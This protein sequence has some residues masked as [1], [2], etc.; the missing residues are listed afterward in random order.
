MDTAWFA[1]DRDGRV[2]R[3]DSGEAGA[4]PNEAATGG[5]AEDPSFDVLLLDVACAIDALESAPRRERTFDL[6]RRAILVI[7]PVATGDYRTPAA[8]SSCES[9]TEMTVVRESSPRVLVTKKQLSPSELATLADH[10]DVRVLVTDEELHEWLDGDAPGL[11]QFAHDGEHYN[12]PGAY[13]RAAPPPQPLRLDAIPESIRKDVERIRLPV[14]FDEIES[15]HL[16]DHMAD[17][18]ASSWDQGPLRGRP[19]GAPIAAPPP[20][21]RGST[22]LVVVVVAVIVV[23]AIL[24][25][26]S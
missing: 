16:A 7:A 26:R 19:E 3:F 14:S 21:K 9:I 6:P 1:I 23:V 13:V 2:A 17:D 20:K 4:V 5:Y 15:L 24:V 18:A 12:E 8:K 11:Y 22:L 25:R 10:P